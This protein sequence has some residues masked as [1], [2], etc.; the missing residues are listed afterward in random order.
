MPQ[1]IAQGPRPNP[2]PACGGEALGLL[3]VLG[4]HEAAQIPEVG[5]P[6]LY[7][8]HAATNLW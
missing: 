5:P 6:K 4:A 2:S 1:G 8:T 3:L 7:C